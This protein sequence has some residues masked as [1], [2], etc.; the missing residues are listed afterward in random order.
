MNKKE[1]NEKRANLIVEALSTP[2]GRKRLF[3]YHYFPMRR[4]F[5]PFE[6]EEQYIESKYQELMEEFKKNE[7]RS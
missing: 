2:E 1:I 3:V 6:T 7:Q 4:S 5:S